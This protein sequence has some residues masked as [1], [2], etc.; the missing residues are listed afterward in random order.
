MSDLNWRWLT[1]VLLG[2]NILAGFVYL[3]SDRT[4]P[5]EPTEIPPMDP[6]IARFELVGE[7]MPGRDGNQDEINCFTIG[8]LPSLLAQ[9]RA[10][11]RLRP[12]TT[13]LRL[14]RTNADHDRG[15]WVY[16]PAASRSAALE[17][18]R[19]LAE[20]GVE[21]Y[22]VVAGGD[23]AN[24]VSVGLYENIDNARGR[25]ARIRD[26]GFDAQVEV[27]RERIP[28]FWVDYRVEADQSPPWR[29]ILRAS[30]GAQR[31]EIPC[32]FSGTP[33]ENDGA[34]TSQ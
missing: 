33:R 2:I 18:T 22:Y 12:F 23:M 25:Q 9:Q 4:V 16:L 24:S 19:A 17:L 3:L 8:P 28:Q 20:Q 21:D 1:I 14:R 31:V 6:G 15:W 27:R 26:L 32:F 11:D 10:E 34:V 30:P 7:A 5:L 13:D 29:F